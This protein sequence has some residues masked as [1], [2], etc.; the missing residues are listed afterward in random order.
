M[1]N[2]EREHAV[3]QL[4]R[5]YCLKRAQAEKEFNDRI[6]FFSGELPVLMRA[7]NMQFSV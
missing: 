1:F 5:E 2:E 7:F 6:P 4:W 3:C